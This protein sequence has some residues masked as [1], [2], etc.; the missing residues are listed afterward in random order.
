MELSNRYIYYCKV[1]QIKPTYILLRGENVNGICHIS[2]I[3]DYL[4]K[5]IND[6]FEVNKSYYFLLL[7]PNDTEHKYKFSYKQIRPKQLK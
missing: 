4:V 1:T 5:N 3:S 7:N 6:Y 2:E